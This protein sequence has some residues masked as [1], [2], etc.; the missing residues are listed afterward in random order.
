MGF[1]VVLE[2]PRIIAAKLP[3]LLAEPVAPAAARSANGGCAGGWVRER[4]RSTIPSNIGIKE[5]AGS[6]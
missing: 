3:V 1:Y 5:S 4:A 6:G 2:V